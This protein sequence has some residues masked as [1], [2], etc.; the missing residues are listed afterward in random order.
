LKKVFAILL[1]LILIVNLS[2]CYRGKDKEDRYS[3]GTTT[4]AA[5][6]AITIPEEIA[7]SDADRQEMEEAFD[8]NYISMVNHFSE[9]I[10]AKL[11]ENQKEN[12]MISPISI[13]MALL[14]AGVGAEG[15]TRDEI[16][17][18][19]GLEG[20][21]PEYILEQNKLLYQLNYLDQ[22][23]SKFRIANSLWLTERM[24][25]KKKYKKMAAGQL[26]ASLYQVDFTK[27]ETAELMRQWVSDNT[28][29]FLDPQIMLSPEQLLS[30]MNTIYFKEEW[31]DEFQ[32]EQTTQDVFYLSEDKAVTC[33]FMNRTNINGTYIENEDYTGIC[34]PLKN[35]YTMYFVLPREGVTVNHLISKTD[36]ISKVIS[37]EQQRYV[38]VIMKIPK[39]NFGTDLE[40]RGTLE[41][42]GVRSAFQAE[43]DFSGI[44][45]GGNVHVS[46]VQHQTH[47]GIDEK[48]VE[49]AAFTN[50]N[51]LGGMQQEDKVEF[52]LNRPFLF[53]ITS[54][55]LILF[56][57][58]V[59]NPT[60]K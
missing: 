35:I 37:G 43:A 23:N 9:K 38:Q 13:Q 3:S 30:I 48:G 15:K 56:M 8:I 27:D 6:A 33:D 11:F 29:G 59:T 31:Q 7:L 41:K 42:L 32:K 51:M 58:V 55:E 46:G 52:T 47:I 17:A 20:K 54:G 60:V 10:T 22:D 2:A 57:G 45:E 36:C 28:G 25:F 53:I 4:C 14:M 1:S 49:A 19:L 18:C 40:L 26:F 16:V 39:F 12:A 44:T 24:S 5:D 34:L 50:M 21:E